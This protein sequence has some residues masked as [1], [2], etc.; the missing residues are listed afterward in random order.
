MGVYD[1]HDPWARIDA[2]RA[3]SDWLPPV[4][5]EQVEW[6]NR[7]VNAHGKSAVRAIFD[8]EGVPNLRSVPEDQRDAF[9]RA[10]TLDLNR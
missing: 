10:V 3:P 6:V 5:A 1:W 4:S 2:L 7:L 8:D 9:L